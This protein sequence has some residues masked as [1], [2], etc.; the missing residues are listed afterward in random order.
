MEDVQDAVQHALTADGFAD[1]A[2]AYAAYRRQRAELREAKELL[3][4]RDELKLG[5]GA[6]AALKERYLLRDEQ[7]RVAEST[8]QMMDQAIYTAAW[9]AGVK[10]I[11]V[12][13]YGARPGQVLTLAA[14]T[15]APDTAVE[16][17][18]AYSGGCG[19]RT[20]EF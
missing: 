10:D 5:L 19:E 20:C 6:V 9:R 18:D 13:R 3:G 17:H 14:P 7:G 12:Y 15:A 1:V 11:T 4:V 8:G 2:R 16:I